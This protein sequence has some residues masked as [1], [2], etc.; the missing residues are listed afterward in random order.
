MIMTAV[1]L[2]APIF[3]LGLMETSTDQMTPLALGPVVALCLLPNAALVFGFRIAA[4][5]E[6]R[7]K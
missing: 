5:F 6:R 4:D 7:G 1:T 3:S 2:I